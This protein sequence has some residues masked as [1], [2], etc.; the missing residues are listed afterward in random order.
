MNVVEEIL[1]K[2]SYELINTKLIVIDPDG[3][4]DVER[5]RAQ[6][7]K[8]MKSFDPRLVN[9]LKVAFI[10]GKYFCFDGQMT[11]KVLKARNKGRD[12]E[13]PCFVFKGLTKVDMADLFCVQQGVASP[14]SFTDVLRIKAHYGDETCLAFIR[15]TEAAGVDIS[16]NGSQSMYTITCVKTAYSS[17]LAFSDKQRYTE[18]LRTMKDAW[19]GY[20]EAFSASLIKGMT[21]LYTTYPELDSARM[22]RKLSLTR[23][24]DIIRDAQVDRTNGVRKYA[25]T[26]LQVYN[27]GA[28]ESMRLPNKI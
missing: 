5:R 1:S 21:I 2:R 8:I 25:V 18:M 19:R 14:V 3:Q 7:N 24:T 22:T 28:R 13:V 12:L 27:K 15:R 6:F 9:P 26:L 23:P 20:K 16:W 4:R 17:F 10:D 11:M